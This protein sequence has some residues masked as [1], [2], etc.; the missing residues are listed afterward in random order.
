MSSTE[1]RTPIGITAIWSEGQSVHKVSLSALALHCVSQAYENV[2]RS[3]VTHI[4]TVVTIAVAIFLLGIFSLFVHNSSTAVARESGEMVV[5]VFLK[6]AASQSEID[7]MAAQLRQ[8]APG[9]SVTYT[10]KAQAL[11]SFRKMLGDDARMLE[12]L[13]VDNPLPASLNVK[14]AS[15]EEAERL[16]GIIVEKLSGHAKV[17]SVR[18][19]RSGVAQIRKMIRLIQIVGAAGMVFLFIIAGFIIANTIKLALYNHRLEIE[20]MQLVG[21]RRG[22]IY[23]PYMLEG[24]A[25]GLLGAAVGVLG[26]LGV[27]LVCRSFLNDATVLQLVLPSFEFIPGIHIVGVLIAGAVVGVTGS[28][29]AVRRFLEDS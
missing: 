7:G 5:M 16:Y 11:S 8:I 13:E 25:Q 26:V 12:G 28:F 14:L 20:I 9:L 15:A 27:F 6:D 17:D 23:A 2:R 18:Y 4:L 1:N 3:S 24:L 22:S 29:L 19:S 10:D 21:A